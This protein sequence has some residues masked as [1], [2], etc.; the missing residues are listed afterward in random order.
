MELQG[1][2]NKDM[3]LI[4]FTA[5]WCQPCKAMKPLIDEYIADHPEVEYAPIDI[6]IDFDSLTTWNVMSVPTFILLDGDKELRRNTG[7]MPRQDFLDFM[8]G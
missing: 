1:W 2:Y 4:H 8:A 5:E 7:A 3:K 6:D